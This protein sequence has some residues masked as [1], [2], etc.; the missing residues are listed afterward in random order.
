[1]GR[2]SLT[3][4]SSPATSSIPGA[5][6]DCIF[7]AWVIPV[8]CPCCVKCWLVVKSEHFA[9]GKCLYGGPF[10]GYLDV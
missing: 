4:G 1:M 10:L 7:E 2:K 6:W 3:A 5:V 9:A 8:S